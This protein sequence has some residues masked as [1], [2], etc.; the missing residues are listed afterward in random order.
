MM[1]KV[2]VVA[3]HP[4]D[5]TLGCGG[6]IL[7]H[8]HNGDKVSSVFVTS[9]N[10]K[11]REIV[12]KVS[13]AYSFDSVH[14][15]DFPELKLS[16]ISLNEIIPAMA[17]VMKAVAPNILYI[18][19]RSDVHSDHRVVFEACLPFTKQFRFPSVREVYMLEV[20]SETDFIPA[21][22]SMAF[23]PNTFVDI[24]PFMERKMEIMSLYESEIMDEDCPRSDSSIRALSRLRGSRI[25]VK[26][27][28]A[29][30]QLMRIK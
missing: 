9:G 19:N 16:D 8:Q 14:Y 13:E 26:Y 2:L 29:F 30:V 20:S 3:V 25:G 4:D 28:E 23:I 15:L 18:P 7:K 22:S 12:K 10:E 5:E 11:Q 1:D 27:A 17:S 24:T 21:L 6:T